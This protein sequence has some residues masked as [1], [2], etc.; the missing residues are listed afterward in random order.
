V[1]PKTYRQIT[2][3][4]TGPQ[5]PKDAIKD[6]PIVHARHATRFVRQERLDGGPFKIGEFVAHDSRLQFR[7]LNHAPGDTINP[8]KPIEADAN[9]LIL[10]PFGS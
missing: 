9:T 2:P 5:D 10:L 1:R 4:R 7:N 3:W 6:A 8:Q